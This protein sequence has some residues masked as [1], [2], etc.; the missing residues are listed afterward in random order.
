MFGRIH[1]LLPAVMGI[2]GAATAWADA[3]YLPQAG[4]MPL[5]FRVPPPPPAEHTDAPM[6]PLLPAPIVLPAPPMPSQ[7]PESSNAP[8]SNTGKPVAVTNG[9]PLE[10]NAREPV[11]G[12]TIIAPDAVISP[13][14]LIKY[15]TVPTSAATNAPIAAPVTP[16]GF[17]PPP[18]TPSAPPPTPG[19]AAPS[20]AP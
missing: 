19:K 9:P 6:P 20:T 14:M 13:Q 18:V 17:T 3:G 2:L 7:P 1:Q 10:F 15:F 12:P 8:P 16:M 11:A 4:P 5:R